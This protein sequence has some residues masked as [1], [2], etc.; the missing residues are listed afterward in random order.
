MSPPGF[1][2]TTFTGNVRERGSA[3]GTTA[4]TE[5]VTVRPPSA[6]RVM[7]T[8]VPVSTPATRRSGTSTVTSSSP[9]SISTATGLPGDSHSPSAVRSS[10]TTPAK[11]ARMT[12][13]SRSSSRRRMSARSWP[14]R[15]R[16][17]SSS[18]RA[19]SNI[20][21]LITSSSKSCR[22]R[23]RLVSACSSRAS[24]SSSPAWADSRLRR[25]FS[26]RNRTSGAPRPTRSPSR[27]SRATTLPS[28]SLATT[29][30]RRE[31]TVP[32]SSRVGR[33]SPRTASV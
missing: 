32:V 30:V 28:T 7:P 21:R 4:R 2:I 10:T 27:A 23:A 12:L 9:T 6:S 20:W 31:S 17:A 18:D 16:H 15:A 11:G 22:A 25:R 26:R 14:A 1:G 5:P 8:G 29:E 24:A 19:S 13:R 33:T 3:R